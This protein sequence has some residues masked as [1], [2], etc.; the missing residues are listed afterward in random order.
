MRQT[1]AEAS[2]NSHW[3]FAARSADATDMLITVTN[4]KGGVGKTMLTVHAAVRAAE[5][6]ANVFVLD[7]DNQA[8]CHEWLSEAA[9]ELMCLASPDASR[10]R[11][12]VTQI[13]GH[14]DVAFADAPPGLGDGTLTLLSLSDLVILPLRPSYADLRATVQTLEAIKSLSSERE[15]NGGGPIDI[16]VVMNMY[17]S[18]DNHTKMVEKTLRQLG[19]RVAHG[20]IGMRTAF[21]NSNRD[22]FV[23]WNAEGRALDRKA[24]DEM[25]GVLDE[26]LPAHLFND[27]ESSST[28]TTS[29]DHEHQD[30]RRDEVRRPHAAG[31]AD[32]A[33]A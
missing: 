8:L 14:V 31:A 26:I 4:Q 1:T 24:V 22:G 9:P 12:V 16:W 18:G 30:E 17:Q 32:R 33:A 21:R 19:A 29:T 6:G 3:R 5:R 7:A 11:E 28:D 10:L 23:V 27:T 15:A 13:R 20:R 25:V 2:D